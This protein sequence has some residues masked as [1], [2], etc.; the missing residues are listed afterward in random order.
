MTPILTSTQMREA[1]RR[2]IDELQIPGMVLMENASRGACDLLATLLGTLRGKRIAVVCG[3]GNNGGDGLALARHALIAGAD[4]T[5]ILL[6]AGEQLSDDARAHYAIM[7]R[8]AAERLVRWEEFDRVE[9][10]WDAVVD[11]MLGTGSSGAPR[12]SFADAV[13]WSNRASG[14]KLAIDIPTGLDADSGAAP[15]PAFI[16]DA[17]AT[18]AALK[19]GLLTGDGAELS[20]DLYVI[21]IGAPEELYRESGLELLD[22]ERA[23]HG[24][25]EVAAGR[26]K[27]DRGKVL[28]AAG[29][30]GMTGA[31]VMAAEAALHAG[32]GLTVLALPEL[33][34]STMPQRLAPE[35]MTLALPS[36]PAGA[37]AADAFATIIENHAAYA[38]IAVGP[39]LSRS[40]EA[41]EAV[42]ALVARST[43]PIILD[44]DGLNAFADAADELARRRCDLV[45]TPHHGEMGRL[46]GVDR[47]EIGRDPI[48]HARDAAR[49]C[50]CIAV[51]KGAPTV[52][53]L[54]D[55]RAWINGAG[56]PGMA[57]GGTG[58]VLTGTIAALIAQSSNFVA[59]TLA[60][61]YL[62]S[63]AAD[64][65]AERR[66]IHALVA[67]DIIAHL[68]DAFRSPASDN[69]DPDND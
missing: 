32:S 34:A 53:A 65:A 22:A 38:A 12:G 33:A 46:L 63:R 62:H 31:A 50:N 61:V 35:I 10:G 15:G 47:E 57:T 27:Y 9:T 1:D 6:G 37:F 56:N 14:V 39:G 7:T 25:P 2:A 58:D 3:K 4:I 54:P 19:P 48:A 18:M 23:T 67:T 8:I 51:L 26:N 24:I 29:S 60:G 49:R 64:I 41:A 16:A 13:A 44:A 11:A 28:V 20:G 59:A 17:T 21:S 40:P 52:V 55:G 42:R 43:S 45:I 69:P 66:G 30:R 36:T 68:A 5:C